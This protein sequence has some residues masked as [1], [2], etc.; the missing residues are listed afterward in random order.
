MRRRYSVFVFLMI[1]LSFIVA[2]SEDAGISVRDP[3]IRE[4]PPGMTVMAGY[5]A[6]RNNTS[7]PQALVAAHSSSFDTLT[8]HRTMV[9]DGMA[10]MVHASRIE[11]ASNA[12]LVFAPGG[13]HLM[14]TNPKQILRAGDRVDIILEFRGGLRLP[15][16]FEIRREEPGREEPVS[17]VMSEHRSH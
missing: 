9:R 13:Y 11:F 8:I 5:M 14:L 7:R 10:G 1:A 3:W 17:S 4:A 12:N 15:V 6:L 2:A 16:S